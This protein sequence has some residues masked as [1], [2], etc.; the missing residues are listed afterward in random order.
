VVRGEILDLYG[1][2]NLAD[3]P[4]YAE[5]KEELKKWLPKVNAKHFRPD[6][7]DWHLR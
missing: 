7:S 2:K 5:A 1:W 4:K 3:D 6:A